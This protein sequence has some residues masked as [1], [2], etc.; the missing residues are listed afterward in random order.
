MTVRESEQCRDCIYRGEISGGYSCDY[1]LRKNEPR[2]SAI[3]NCD[4]YKKRKSSGTGK[5]TSHPS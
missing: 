2:R 4:K 3:G 1:I 5:R